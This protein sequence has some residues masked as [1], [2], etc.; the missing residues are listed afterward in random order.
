MGLVDDGIAPRHARRA[1]VAPGEGAVDH[2]AFRHAARVVAAVERQVFAGRADPVAEMGV[3]PAERSEQRLG[4]GVDQ[5]LVGV[6]AVAGGRLVGAVDPVAVERAGA[7]F[8]QIAVP[9]LVR[10]F[11]QR[12]PVDL[13]GAGLVEQA[14]LDPGRIGREQGEIDAEAVPGGAERIGTARPDHGARR[15]R[16]LHGWSPWMVERRGERGE[17]A[18]TGP[19]ALICASGRRCGRVEGV[20]NPRA[21]QVVPDFAAYDHRLSVWGLRVCGLQGIGG[22]TLGVAAP[23]A[24]S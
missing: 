3:G 20:G 9:D 11:R 16:R 15:A 13:A 19:A 7:R 8:R 22:R 24:R 17:L 14:Q 4:V 18:V 10:V 23:A 1:V 2:A 21:A 12:H 5:Q 6:E